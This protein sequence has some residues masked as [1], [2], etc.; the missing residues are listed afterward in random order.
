MAINWTSWG[1]VPLVNYVS[2]YFNR[3]AEVT[4]NDVLLAW[5]VTTGGT[6]STPSGWTLQRTYSNGVRVYLFSRVVANI[7]T[8]PSQYTFSASGV[9]GYAAL[10]GYSGVNN[11]SP[12]NAVSTGYGDGSSASVTFQ[13]QTLNLNGGNKWLVFLGSLG[14]VSATWFGSNVA[15]N[16]DISGSY[17]SYSFASAT[18]DITGS[19]NVPVVTG[20]TSQGAYK[21]T[22]TIGLNHA[23]TAPAAAGLQQPLNNIGVD[24]QASVYFDWHHNDVTWQPQ[25]SALL[26]YRVYGTS[27]WTDVTINGATTEY[28]MPANTFALDTR[29]E[30]RVTTTNTAGL[31]GPA[32]GTSTFW[33]RNKPPTP[34]I[35]SPAADGNNVSAEHTVTWTATNQS[36]Y[37]VRIWSADEFGDP[38]EIISDTEMVVSSSARSR[39]MA[40]PTNGVVNWIEVLVRYN[41][42][43]STSAWRQVNVVY[44]PPAAPTSMTFSPENMGTSP[45][46]YPSAMR[47]SFNNP[48][49]TGSQPAVKQAELWVNE[50]NYG[51]GRKLVTFGSQGQSNPWNW[52][53]YYPE[54]G[55]TYYYKVILIGAN[56]SKY[57]TIWTL[58]NGAAT[59][60]GTGFVLQDTASPSYPVRYFAL[61]DAGASEFLEVESALIDVQGRTYPMVEWGD[62]KHKTI[63]IPIIHSEGSTDAYFLQEFME[64]RSVLCYRDHKGRVEFGRLRQGDIKDKFYGYVTSLQFDVVD[65]GDEPFFTTAS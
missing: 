17:A 48:T 33:A 54:L 10:L 19:T 25:Q 23:A 24:R 65:Y 61:N 4:T 50:L 20:E 52:T 51:T 41:Y 36:E 2:F 13:S 57:E 63:D 21:A 49:P 15:E 5:V 37:R 62:G 56:G 64:R 45:Y 28:Y 42:V 6:V 30:W 3:P 58:A 29:Y 47:L 14:S 32:S 53:W 31:T 22:V 27:T 39:L 16:G 60:A 18:L 38:L 11:A 55:R 43:W 9:Y 12:V 46:V 7:A 8:E 26:Q 34:V 40:F 1:H 59:G 35:T 44:T